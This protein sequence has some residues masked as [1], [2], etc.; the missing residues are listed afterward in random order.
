MSDLTKIAFDSRLNYLKRSEFVGSETVTLGGAGSNSTVTVT[1]GI[2]DIPFVTVGVNL[3]DTSTI[4][5][6][7]R[8]WSETQSSLSGG[9]L[10]IGYNYWI[11]TTTL[12]IQ[13]RNGDGAYA[14][15]GNRTVYWSIY[16]DYEV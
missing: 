2:G 15:S 6:N 5:S 12:T 13:I 4:W 9:D 7:D 16:K 11:T 3:T 14:Q 10:E 8:V 1:H